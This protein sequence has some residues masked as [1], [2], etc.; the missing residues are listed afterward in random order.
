MPESS[1]R[2]L[3]RF[4]PMRL[5]AGPASAP[6]T[7]RTPSTTAVGNSLKRSRMSRHFACRSAS[8]WSSNGFGVDTFDRASSL[9]F[10]EFSGYRNES[11][12]VTE[13]A[14]SQWR[15]AKGLRSVRPLTDTFTDSWGILAASWSFEGCRRGTSMMA[16]EEGLEP[17][18]PRLTAACSTIELLWNSEERVKYK[19]PPDPS[20]DF[21]GFKGSQ[22][23]PTR[24]FVCARGNRQMSCHE[25]EQGYLTSD[26][27]RDRPAVPVRSSHGC[28]CSRGTARRLRCLPARSGRGCIAR[29]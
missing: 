17:S 28:C 18:T 1:T 29:A 2:L 3:L 10:P 8:T 12:P 6:R 16:P 5:A 7:R 26:T 24:S 25:L 27:S 9:R 23:S 19:P 21:P 20:T 13:Q 15:A 4:G 11:I 14:A 22:C